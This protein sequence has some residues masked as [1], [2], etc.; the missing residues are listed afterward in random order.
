MEIVYLITVTAVTGLWLWISILSILC[1]F[2]DPDLEPI[3]RWGQAIIVVL[4][5]Y[6]GALFILKMVNEHSPEVVSKFYIPW[7]FKNIVLDKSLRHG[8]S[9][10][11]REEQPGMH[12]EAINSTSDSSGGGGD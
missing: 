10:N 2:L 5:P 9:G 8:G 12:K 11:N 7:P 3:Q 4:L 1:L 6:I